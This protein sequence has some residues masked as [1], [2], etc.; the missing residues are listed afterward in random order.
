MPVQRIELQPPIIVP[1][2]RLDVVASA[3]VN[4]SYYADASLKRTILGPGDEQIKT[5]SVFGGAI[6]HKVKADKDGSGNGVYENST[7]T[8]MPKG[9]GQCIKK[10][11][12]AV[13]I[14]PETRPIPIFESL[15]DTRVRLREIYCFVSR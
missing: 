5:F 7:L 14:N 8:E 4:G 10:S 12:V 11:V 13:V 9:S 2:H 15:G 6:E 3:I 1:N